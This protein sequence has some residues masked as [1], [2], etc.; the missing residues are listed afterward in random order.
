M[1][2]NWKFYP[3]S[4]LVEAATLVADIGTS[5][6]KDNILNNRKLSLLNVD[7]VTAGQYRLQ[8]DVGSG[9][10]IDPDFM[11]LVNHNLYTDTATVG[12]THSTA[13]TVTGTAPSPVATDSFTVVTMTSAHQPIFVKTGIIVLA[14][15]Y[16]WLDITTSSAIAY[17]GQLL[18]GVTV[19]PSVDPNWESPIEIDIESGRIVNIS[20]GGFNWKTRTHG[21]KQGWQV[22]Y[23]F[24]SDADVTL[25]KAWLADDDFID[26]PFVFTNDGGTTYYYGELMGNPQFKPVQAGLTDLEFFISEVIA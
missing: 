1:A 21:I 14:K 7:T 5:S 20:P 6:T 9:N 24:L 11:A 16:W 19:N 10:T 12:L 25:F 26:T 13:D 22:K 18:I 4:P 23:Q 3:Q 15:R 2:T 8:I 17:I